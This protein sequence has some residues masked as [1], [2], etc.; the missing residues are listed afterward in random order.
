MKIA[1]LIY[2][3]AGGGAERQLSYVLS[4]C[5]KNNIKAHLVLMNSTIKYNIPEDTEIH[6]LEKSSAVES[7]LIKAMK[8][9]VLAY[10]YGRLLRH[11]NITHS[12][13]MLT[14]PNFINVLASKLSNY[15][16]KVITNELAFPTLQYNYKGFQSKFN[17]R[18][19]DL[20]YKKSDLVIGNS[21]GNAQDLIHNFSVPK[22]KMA[23]VHNP[24]D[25]KKIEHID[26][27]DDFFDSQYYNLVTLGRLD[28]GKNHEMLIRAVEQLK[29]PKIRLYIFGEGPMLGI[30]ED[31]IESLEIKEQIFLMGF[32]PNPYKYLKSADL[33]VFG[34]N[35]EGFP[36]VILEAM[37]CNLPVLTTN[38]KSG[39]AEIMRLSNPK[40]DLMLTDLGIL[41]PIKDVN[42]MSKGI[43]YFLNNKNYSMKCQSNGLERIRDFEK[44]KI[45]IEYMD[46]ITSL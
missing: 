22:E 37:A 18:L 23:V 45:L 14:R 38:C 34:S 40:N 25:L 1:F 5:S 8:I 46:I 10:R 29:N 42:L 36:N 7:G 17:K 12:V 16:F 26:P 43:E 24:I 27:I 39:P 35:H 15:K 20:L 41:T 4:Y 31:L 28:I 33:F 11:L 6:Y 30:L 9:P 3:L 13:S 32:D 19:I 21:L 44:E 2:S